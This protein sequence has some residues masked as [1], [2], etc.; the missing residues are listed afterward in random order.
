MIDRFHHIYVHAGDFDRSL[1]FLIATRSA[2][3]SR[4]PGVAKRKRAARSFPAAASRSWWPRRK[5]GQRSEPGPGVFL[6][7]H[8]I[9]A[10]FMQCPRA[11]HV[12]TPP[13]PTKWGTRWFVVKDPDG[14]QIAFEEVH[15][16]PR[17]RG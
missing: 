15:N 4:A 3:P 17:N 11:D 2:G 14:N 7:I 16:F 13:G 9:D 10:R 6:D 8:D 5:S 12:V 1:A